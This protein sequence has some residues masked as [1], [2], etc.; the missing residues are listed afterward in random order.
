[1][2]NLKK[3]FYDKIKNSKVTDT[4][5][6]C[7]KKKDL[8]N[9]I[10]LKFKSNY[11]GLLKLEILEFKNFV[12]HNTQSKSLSP[13]G[14]SYDIVY[15][16]FNDVINS[17]VKYGCSENFLVGISTN[18]TIPEND[19]CE[20]KID[21]SLDEFDDCPVCKELLFDNNPV[22]L[23]CNHTICRDCLIDVVKT[24]PHCPICRNPLGRVNIG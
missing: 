24:N 2:D 17:F 4:T 15:I 7:R 10:R 20:F 14:K 23:D 18:N 5:I 22:N 1:M 8:G 19:L 3:F 11:D 13:F 6:F 21:K 16:T 12:S 9:Q